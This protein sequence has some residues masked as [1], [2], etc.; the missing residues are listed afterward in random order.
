MT[1]FKCKLCKPKNRV[2]MDRR[3]F[4]KHMREEHNITSEI[5]NKDYIIGKGY[6]RQNWVI[7]DEDDE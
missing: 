7:E 6:V 2:K 4:R 1:T 5:I 3:N